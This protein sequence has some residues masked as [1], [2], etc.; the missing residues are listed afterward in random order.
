M[1]KKFLRNMYHANVSVN[2]MEGNLK[3]KCECKKH[4]IC[5]KDCNHPTCIFQKW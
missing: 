5:E 4:Q 1:N 2:L 3:N